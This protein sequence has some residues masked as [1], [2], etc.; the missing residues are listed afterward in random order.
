L[1]IKNIP[2]NS[3]PYFQHEQ[4]LDIVITWEQY[5]RKCHRWVFHYSANK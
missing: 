5:I 1:K 2:N 3:T 4:N